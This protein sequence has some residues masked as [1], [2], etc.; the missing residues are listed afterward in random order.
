MLISPY[1]SP[2]I[3]NAIDATVG[4]ASFSISL[5]LSINFLKHWERN[6]KHRK[7]SFWQEVNG[8]A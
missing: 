6:D 5:E 7:I 3:I 4:I 1:L 8:I 2:F